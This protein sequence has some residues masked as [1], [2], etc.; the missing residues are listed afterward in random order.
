MKQRIQVRMTRNRGRGVFANCGIKKGEIIESAPVI[1]LSQKEAAAMQKWSL[2]SHF[3]SWGVRGNYSA[4]VLGFA[5]FYNHSYEPNA[6]YT[7]SLRRKT[8]VFRAL[9]D[10]RPG[11]EIRH[12]YNGSPRSKRPVLFTK[13]GWTFGEATKK[14]S[15][16]GIR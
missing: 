10:I 15:K 8:I 2:A 4:L 12:N 7:H 13:D 9:R 14:I 5:C 11:E 3:Y 1:V 6:A 16:G